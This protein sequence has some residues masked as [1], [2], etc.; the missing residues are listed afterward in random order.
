MPFLT[1]CYSSAICKSAAVGLGFDRAFGFG[2][3]GDHYM[4]DIDDKHKRW[5]ELDNKGSV[6]PEWEAFD[7]F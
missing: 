4:G 5:V 7:L 1:V 6:S 2:D 3:G